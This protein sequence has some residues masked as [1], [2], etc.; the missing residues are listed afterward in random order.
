MCFSP[1]SP[2]SKAPVVS[3]SEDDYQPSNAPLLDVSDSEGTWL[4]SPTKGFKR[5]FQGRRMKDGTK[6][7]RLAVTT[8]QEDAT[9]DGIVEVSDYTYSV[10]VSGT[11]NGADTSSNLQDF[12]PV[13]DENFERYV[14]MLDAGCLGYERVGRHLYVVQGWDSARSEGQEV[15]YHMEARLVGERMQLTCLCR[16]GRVQ[17][18]PC[19]HQEFYIEFRESH[20]KSQEHL[21]YRDGTVVMFWHEQ[22]GWADGR[23]LIRFSVEGING[24]M[25]NRAIVTYEGLENGWGH[26]KC[27]KDKKEVD[28]LH[29]RR[30]RKFL[31]EVL[32]T[33]LTNESG[34]QTLPN[35]SENLE[36]TA[37]E[38]TEESAVSFLPILAPAWATL[39]TDQLLYTRPHPGREVPP[40][41][42][43]E[44]GRARSACQHSTCYDPLQ[45]TIQRQSTVYTLT[46][47]KTVTIELQ[48]CPTCPKRHHCYIGPE[49][50]DMGVFNYNNNVLF[51]HELLDEYTSRFVSSETPFAA[52][53]QSIGRIYE[54]RGVKFIGDDLFRAVWFAYVSLQS[55][56]HDMKC[57]RCGDMPETVIWDGVTLAFSKKHLKDC[58]KPPTN[59]EAGSA[60]RGRRY[61]KNPQWVPLTAK[62]DKALRKDFVSWLRGGKRKRLEPFNVDSDVESGPAE[63]E[64]GKQDLLASFT[65]RIQTTAPALAKV[66]AYVLGPGNQVDQGLTKRYIILFEQLVAEESAMQMVNESA[67]ENLQTFIRIRSLESATALVDIPALLLVLEGEIRLRGKV[68]WEL[69]DLCSWMC[70]RAK[71]V[72]DDLKKGSL[73]ELEIQLSATENDWRKVAITVFRKSVL[74]L[75]IRDWQEMKD[76]IKRMHEARSVPSTIQRTGNVD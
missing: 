45:P 35:D 1:H 13:E 31:G 39:P 3:D 66:L 24:A 7:V 44:P 15:W 69:F 50:R 75:G 71:E 29:I 18:Q 6:R 73:D 55:L 20:F 63:S 17:A 38:L 22:V 76:Q 25:N 46:E 70:V 58:L 60:S 11:E 34:D 30:A 48:A 59:I 47:C 57:P 14:R 51:T 4:R 33:S 41:F 72:L 68:P 32:G 26:W 16:E 19:I 49:P 53:V 43:L 67:L 40:L 10:E 28:C 8:T 42:A 27:T 2:D 54:G 65:S 64:T 36:S 37:N 5:R 56:E 52:F 61:I 62:G 23:V 12:Q 74:G 21:W 9:E